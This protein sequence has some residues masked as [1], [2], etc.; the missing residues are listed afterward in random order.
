[1]AKKAAKKKAAKKKTGS[2]KTRSRITSK[3]MGAKKTT[4]KKKRVIVK[5]PPQ[6]QPQEGVL[7]KMKNVLEETTEKLKTLLPGENAAKE[8]DRP[9]GE[10]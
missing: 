6:E 7:A 10:S 4:A 5:K 1:M 3:K 8:P 9:T 2:K